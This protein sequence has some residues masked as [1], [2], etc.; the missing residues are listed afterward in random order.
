LTIEL[1][2]IL[3]MANDPADASIELDGTGLYLEESFTDRRVGSVQRLSPVTRNGEPDASRPV[4]YIGQTQ[5]L[6]PAGALPLS[7]EIDARSLE[8]AIGKFGD[9]ARQALAN[10]MEQLEELRR[11]QASSLIVPGTAAPGPRGPG[12]GGRGMGGAGGIQVP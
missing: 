8:D 10:T 1:E 5:I 12:M 6:T 7:F 4:L 9:Y 11:E 3:I 2:G